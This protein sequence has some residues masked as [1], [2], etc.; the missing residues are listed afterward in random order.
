MKEIMETYGKALLAA[1]AVGSMMMLLF[2]G[3]ADQ[4]GIAG[5]AMGKL[6]DG[7]GISAS[8]QIPSISRKVRKEQICRK[9]PE[10]TSDTLQAGCT[11]ET[12][13]IIRGTDAK[14]EAVAVCVLRIRG[15]EE[16]DTKRVMFEQPGIYEA[17]VVA[18]DTQGI[19]DYGW[20]YLRV[21]G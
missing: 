14:G 12:D 17:Y 10:I 2:W 8:S 21:E 5:A 4:K 19:L 18:K 6:Q 11:Y 7:S 15:N 13:Q 1:V 3:G 9:A 16:K 20:I